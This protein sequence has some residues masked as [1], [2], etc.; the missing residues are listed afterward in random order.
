[1]PPRTKAIAAGHRDLARSFPLRPQ[2]HIRH[3]LKGFGLLAHE[4]SA[5]VIADRE[6]AIVSTLYN[7]AYLTLQRHLG[8]PCETFSDQSDSIANFET[9]FQVRL[10]LP[11]HSRTI[12]A[13]RHAATKLAR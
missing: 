10:S 5:I 3:A 11:L 9:I 1:M 7:V 8:F 6:P 4:K 2:T 13:P 12:E